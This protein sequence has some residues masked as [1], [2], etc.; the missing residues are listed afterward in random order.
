MRLQKSRATLHVSQPSKAAARNATPYPAEVNLRPSGQPRDVYG[1]RQTPFGPKSW[2][3]R[4]LWPCS[5]RTRP[6][7]TLNLNPKPQAREGGLKGFKASGVHRASRASRVWAWGLLAGLKG[8]RVGSF[9]ASEVW[10]RGFRGF[11]V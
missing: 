2:V 1:S 6:I 4:V 3:F 7:E 9:W 10:G 5:L 11:R 8:L